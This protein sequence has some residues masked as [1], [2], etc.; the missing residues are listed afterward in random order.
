[1]NDKV[2]LSIVLPCYNEAKN[3]PLLLERFKEIKNACPFELILVNNGSTDNSAEVLRQELARPGHSFARTVLVEKN[4]GY[5]YGV[6]S[7]LRNAR[8]EYIAYS[9]ADLQCAPKDV[10]TAYWKLIEKDNPRRFIL[11]GWRQGRPLDAM[12]ITWG[13][14]LIASIILLLPLSDINGQPKV[15]HRDFLQRL[16]D[17]PKGFEF[18]LYVLYRA[19]RSNM[20]IDTVPVYFGARRHG[21][22][23]WAYSLR[24][25]LRTI[26]GFIRYI[27]GLRCTEIAN[28][29]YHTSGYRG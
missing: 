21:Q 6:M 10:F 15:F 13:L 9:H 8:G 19:L 14:Q 11:K 18:D 7:G 26:S 29:F 12:I 1:M 16:V 5:G 27:I 4:Q 24:S 2:I 28:G 23:N 3:I 17:P 22:S 20:T 25:K